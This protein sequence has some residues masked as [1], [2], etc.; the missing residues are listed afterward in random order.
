MNPNAHILYVDDDANLLA[1]E[2]VRLRRLGYEVTTRPNAQVALKTLE[3]SPEAYDL[4]ITDYKM[5]GMNGVELAEE[6]RDGGYEFPMVLMSGYQ[7]D[8]PA[9]EAHNAGINVILAKPVQ[10][11]ELKAQLDLLL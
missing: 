8:L 7:G 2:S 1:L 4:L 5:P 9:H 11:E 3:S 10:N 6:L